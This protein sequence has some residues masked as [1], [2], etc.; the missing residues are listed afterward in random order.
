MHQER[1]Q[2][3]LQEETSR[4]SGV[5][6]RDS[7]LKA[8]NSL[9]A[10]R[11]REIRRVSEKLL[12]LWALSSYPSPATPKFCTSSSINLP[13]NGT[14]RNPLR[15]CIFRVAG[16]NTHLLDFILVSLSTDIERMILNI[17]PS[18]H[19][20]TLII[21]PDILSDSIIHGYTCGPR[22]SRERG[23]CLILLEHTIEHFI[24]HGTPDHGSVETSVSTLAE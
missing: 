7:G 2:N 24:C 20:R 10:G 13:S 17:V 3:R 11:P 8:P 1:S 6:T 5:Q 23:F 19:Q 15:G 21:L 14:T 9:R 22:K 12:Y 16:M 18:L 4:K